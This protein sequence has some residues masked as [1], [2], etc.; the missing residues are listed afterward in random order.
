M[1]DVLLEAVKQHPQKFGTG[2]ARDVVEA[3]RLIETTFDNTQRQ[4][5]FLQNE[6]FGFIMENVGGVIQNEVLRIDLFRGIK[7]HPKSGKPDFE[8]GLFHAFDHFSYQGT[9]LATGS[10][11]ND[12]AHP[13][14][15]IGLAIKAFF[16]PEEK[17]ETAKG[18]IGRISLDENNWLKFSFY[19]EPVNGVHF[20]STVHKER[21]RKR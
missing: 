5:E 9:N 20:I 18:F 4:A 6:Q 19:Y 7:P 13:E 17:E 10:D 2:D 12:I 15:I 21:K 16:M 8:G 14:E 11:K 3:I 1:K